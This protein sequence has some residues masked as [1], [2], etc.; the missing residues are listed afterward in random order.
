M[1]VGNLSL[2]ADGLIILSTGN[3]PINLGDNFL[4]VSFNLTTLADNQIF[5]S[6]LVVRSRRS[7]SISK[8]LVL[9][10]CPEECLLGL[11]PDPSSPPHMVLD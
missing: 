4:G 3:G 11:P 9:F 2:M 7:V 10:C 5:F 1:E 8:L 6:H